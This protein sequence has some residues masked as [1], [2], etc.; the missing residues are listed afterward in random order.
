[1]PADIHYWHDH[2]AWLPVTCYDG[3]EAWLVL[4]QRRVHPGRYSRTKPGPF[5]QY[6]MPPPD[7]FNLAG[8]CA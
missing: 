4:V 8:A 3:R 5:W 7:A 6:R 1:M 2:F